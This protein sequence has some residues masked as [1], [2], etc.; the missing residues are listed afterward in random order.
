MATKDLNYFKQE[1]IKILEKKEATE[2]KELKKSLRDFENEGVKTLVKSVLTGAL[3]IEKANYPVGTVRTWKGERYKK[4]APG[5]WRKMLDASGRGAKMSLEHMKKK[6]MAA[7]SVDELLEFV[8][9]Q[10]QRFEGPDADKLISELREAVNSQK[11]KINGKPTATVTNVGT[12]TEEKKTEENKIIESKTERA[13]IYDKAFKDNRDK[14]SKMSKD[15]L[16]NANK[17]LQKQQEGLDKHSEKYVKLDGERYAVMVAAAE[18]TEKKSREDHKKE[19]INA[20]KNDKELYE[21][22]KKE[23]K[24]LPI[25]QIGETLNKYHDAKMREMKAKGIDVTAGPEVDGFVD[26]I[27]EVVKEIR[28]EQAKEPKEPSEVKPEN[29]TKTNVTEE[30]KE[31]AKEDEKLEAPSKTPEDIQKE[32]NEINELYKKYSNDYH[33]GIGYWLL[34]RRGD[35]VH[36]KAFCRAKGATLM[37]NMKADLES[38]GYTMPDLPKELMDKAKEYKEKI[39]GIPSYSISSETDKILSGIS[40]TKLEKWVNEFL[41]PLRDKYNELKEQLPAK[42]KRTYTDEEKNKIQEQVNKYV[43]EEMKKEHATKW[44]VETTLKKLGEKKLK[45]L[46]EMEVMSDEEFSSLVKEKLV[47]NTMDK[48]KDEFEE[49]SHWQLFLDHQ[50]NKM[51]KQMA[52]EKLNILDSNKNNVDIPV[53]P[54]LM[55]E[56]ESIIGRDVARILNPN[57]PSYSKTNGRQTLKDKIQRRIR[58]DPGL[59]RAMLMYIKQEQE[60]TGST[61]F[62][63]TNEIWDNLPQLNKIAEEAAMSGESET[64]KGVSGALYSGDD[65]TEIVENKDIGRYQITFPGKP[66]AETRNYL[67][68]HGF[69]W[70]P[71]SGTWQCYNTAN[72]ERS[73]K[74]AAEYLGLKN[75]SDVQ[76]SF[77]HSWEGWV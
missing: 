69:R 39:A 6:I 45:E 30:I 36:H 7:Q 21:Q 77:Y 70:A 23:L 47:K 73:M 68:S 49:G 66:D 31:E 33:A 38:K 18:I 9:Q 75:N 14:Y 24:D 46:A 12:K 50:W 2:K 15:E 37:E 1:L 29:E 52:Q 74:A 32:M 8:T 10:W 65:G 44:N 41:Q 61:V 19:N 58:N 60:R 67:K 3:T 5:K 4:I 25:P 71:S 35:D 17:E 53:A 51:A 43:D 59:A 26:A 42:E 55:T 56:A 27:T 72:G 64:K 57:A 48:E 20:I 76:K 28:E 54:E 16:I 11:G 34:P 13:D 22:I 40:S 63:Q 62:T